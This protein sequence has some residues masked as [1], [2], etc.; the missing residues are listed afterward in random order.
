MIWL[1][2]SRTSSSYACAN[3]V[4]WPLFSSQSQLIV[5]YL[6]LSD[7]AL[8]VSGAGM[9]SKSDSGYVSTFSNLVLK[10]RPSSAF[11][12]SLS[13]AWDE[14]C[15]LSCI[16]HVYVS[17]P[18]EFQSATSSAITQKKIMLGR[19]RNAGP[20]WWSTCRVQ[21]ASSSSLLQLDWRQ[22]VLMTQYLSE[23]GFHNYALSDV[24]LSLA[25][26]VCPDAHLLGEKSVWA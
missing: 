4:P 13:H 25:S 18:L 10:L 8:T 17:A 3:W 15:C 2:S 20:A 21:R 11:E 16:F 1:N 22:R 24:D 6:P 14:K 9:V 7:L 26:I 12:V 19:C 23:C 5:S